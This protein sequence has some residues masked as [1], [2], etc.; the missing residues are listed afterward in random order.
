[1]NNFYQWKTVLVTGSTGFKWSWL[2]LWLHHLGAN[3]IGYSLPANTQPNLF[4]VLDLES[5]IT[6]IYADINDLESLQ[7]VCE[8]YKPE[9]VFHL[10]AQPLVRESYRDPVWTFQTNV[11]GT[12]NVLEAIR[13]TESIKWAVLI[14]TDKVYENLETMRPYLETDRLGW[15][16]PYSTSKAMDELAITSYVRSFFS[17]GEKKIVSVRAGNVIGGGDWSAERL[18]PDII[19][20]FEKGEPVTLR[21]PYSVRPWQ[22]VLEPLSGYLM[23]G[24]KIFQDDKYLW[25][26]NFGPD[27]SDTMRV[28]DIVK[29]A[30]KILWKWEYKIQRDETMHEAGL[31]LLDNTKSKTL[32]GWSPRF[33]VDDAIKS[34]LEWYRAYADGKNMREYSLEQIWLFVKDDTIKIW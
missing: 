26:Y 5:Q 21:N 28:E 24:E 18:I 25:A 3:V 6:Q 31:L 29:K 20:A 4:H 32:L 27:A 33:G 7:G 9:I 23:M 13:Q 34:T 16:D 14:T 1:M 8:E 17:H 2:S 22:H 30:I 11:M 12:V 19:R 15:Y 10:A